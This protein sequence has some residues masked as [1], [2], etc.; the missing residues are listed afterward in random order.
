[1]EET[2][3]DHEGNNKQMSKETVLLSVEVILRYV[4]GLEKNTENMS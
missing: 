3:T 1:M 4:M 2:Y